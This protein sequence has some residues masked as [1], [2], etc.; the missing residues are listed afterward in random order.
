MPRT[1]RPRS[2]RTRKPERSLRADLATPVAMNRAPAPPSALPASHSPS[3]LPLAVTRQAQREMDR[4]RRLPPGSPEAGQVRAYLQ[5]LWS[6]PW[7]QAASE[8]ADFKQVEAELEREHLGLA[9]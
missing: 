8:D 6:M 2:L 1:P 9:K 3:R 4:L 5:W 7:D